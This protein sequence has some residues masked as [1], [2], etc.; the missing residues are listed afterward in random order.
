[1]KRYLYIFVLVLLSSFK[2]TSDCESNF[3]GKFIYENEAYKGVYIET[4]KNKHVEY[5]NDGESYIESKKEYIDNCTFKLTVTKIK[6]PS[7]GLKVGDVMII[8]I[9][10]F[11]N[12]K[13][14]LSAEIEGYPQ[15]KMKLIKID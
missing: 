1:M 13:L 8:K 15:I 14:S 7:V 5:Y 11:E 12:K 4:S 2:L 6:M 10:E 3:N 9:H